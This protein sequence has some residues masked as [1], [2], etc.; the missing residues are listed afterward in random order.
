MQYTQNNYRCLEEQTDLGMTFQRASLAKLNVSEGLERVALEHDTYEV[1][2]YELQNFLSK[3]RRLIC[4]FDVEIKHEF[5]KSPLELLPSF[6][7][8]CTL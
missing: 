4:R 6:F 3:V 8:C 5:T 1:K 2:Y 7:T